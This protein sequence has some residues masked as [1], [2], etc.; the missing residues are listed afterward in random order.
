[1]GLDLLLCS[2]FALH[3][4]AAFSSEGFCYYKEL[5][6]ADA[7]AN[8]V[9]S[10]GKYVEIS[11]S[12]KVE[13]SS[14]TAQPNI[15]LLYADDLGLGD[16]SAFNS[17]SKIPTNNLDE[18]A[19]SGRMFMDA[20]SSAGTCSPSRYSMLTGRYHWRRFNDVVTSFGGPVISSERL[21]LPRMLNESGYHTALIGK[22]HLGWDW[23]SIRKRKKST[24]HEDF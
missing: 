18:L 1:M 16:L 14:S 12:P 11:D 6:H 4:L 8:C 5:S 23:D 7:E 17:D 10:G 9:Q 3:F 22:W 19:N 13:R 24:S 2:L 21:T 15:L 20:H